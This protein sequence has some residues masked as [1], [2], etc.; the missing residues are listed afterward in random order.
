MTEPAKPPT[1]LTPGRKPLGPAL[2]RTAADIDRLA[3]ITDEDVL[4]ARDLWHDLAPDGYQGLID[5]RV[6]PAAP[7]QSKAG[8]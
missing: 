1:P 3:K 5:A 8:S 7:S 4:D 6:P 2:H